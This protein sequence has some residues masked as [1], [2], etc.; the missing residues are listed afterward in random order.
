M[1]LTF[2]FCGFNL[3]SFLRVLSFERVNGLEEKIR[4]LLGGNYNI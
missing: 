3:K 2:Q 1:I 4:E